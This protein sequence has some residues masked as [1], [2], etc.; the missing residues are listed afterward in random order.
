MDS[1]NQKLGMTPPLGILCIGVLLIGVVVV[2]SFIMEHD[3]KEKL[4]KNFQHFKSEYEKSI[5][6][7]NGEALTQNGGKL[8]ASQ[9]GNVHYFYQINPTNGLRIPLPDHKVMLNAFESSARVMGPVVSVAP[10]ITFYNGKMAY[11]GMWVTFMPKPP[12][13]LR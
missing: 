9:Q 8:E 11:M 7:Q 10:E 6:T 3:D 12:E 13:S 4:A 1:S 5:P 2:M